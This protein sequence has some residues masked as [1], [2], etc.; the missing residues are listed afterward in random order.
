MSKAT[1]YHNPRCSK[2]RDSLALLEEKGFDCSVIEYLNDTPSKDEL[3]EICKKMNGDARTILREKESLWQDT[4][5][6]LNPSN[7]ELLDLMVANPILIE[8]PIVIVGDKAAIGRP[9]TNILP[10]LG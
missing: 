1:I 5:K 9:A 3:K 4:H 8:R 2:S 10:I 6:A 7:E